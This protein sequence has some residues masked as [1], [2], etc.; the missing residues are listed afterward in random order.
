MHLREQEI[1]KGSGFIDFFDSGSSVPI[2][3]HDHAGRAESA[4]GT[5]HVRQ[6]LLNGVHLSPGAAQAF[7]GCDLQAVTAQ[8]GSQ[9]L[10]EKK[11]EKKGR[12]RLLNQNLKFKMLL[13]H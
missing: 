3:C 12:V 9:T 11:K 1:K 5:V 13:P 4:L 2:H 10:E 6:P 7:H 8:D